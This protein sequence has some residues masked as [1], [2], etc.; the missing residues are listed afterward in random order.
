M[1]ELLGQYL[2]QLAADDRGR[3]ITLAEGSPGRALMLVEDEGLKIATL[4]DKLLSDMPGIPASRGYEIADFLGRSETGFSTFM[5]LMR[6]GVA[7]AVRETVRGRA[8]PE[9]QRLVAL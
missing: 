4:V 3:L 5:D 1:E 7:A 9:Q 8:D 2:P 6:A